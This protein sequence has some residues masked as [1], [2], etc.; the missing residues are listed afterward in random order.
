MGT[1]LEVR[2]RGE[3]DKESEAARSGRVLQLLIWSESKELY[4]Y[5]ELKDDGSDVRFD[6]LTV[7]RWR[8][9]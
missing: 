7:A 2:Q 6:R 1:D 3:S 5:V 9:N 4:V 8:A